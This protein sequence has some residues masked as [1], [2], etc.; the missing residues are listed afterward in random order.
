MW[1][2]SFIFYILLHVQEQTMNLNTFPCHL[3]FGWPLLHPLVIL[4][5]QDCRMLNYNLCYIWKLTFVTSSTMW[6]P[7]CYFTVG[8]FINIDS[9]LWFL[10]YLFLI[11]RVVFSMIAKLILWQYELKNLVLSGDISEPFIA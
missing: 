8:E 5:I 11:F 2:P 10:P 6:Y 9:F 4:I 1:F 7:R 3:Q